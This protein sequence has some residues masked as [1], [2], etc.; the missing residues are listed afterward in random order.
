MQW[1]RKNALA[2]RARGAP[3]AALQCVQESARNLG[4]GVDPYGPSD[5][6]RLER[7]LTF[8]DAQRY[9][10]WYRIEAKLQEEGKALDPAPSCSSSPFSAVYHGVLTAVLPYSCGS[11]EVESTAL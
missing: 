3:E 6:V 11:R 10:R 8:S 1:F 7:Q 9:V 2:Y 5:R 4:Y